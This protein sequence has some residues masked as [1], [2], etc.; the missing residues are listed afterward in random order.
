VALGPRFEKPLIRSFVRRRLTTSLVRSLGTASFLCLCFCLEGWAA[1]AADYTLGPDDQL[2]ISVFDLRAGTGQPYQWTAFNNPFRVDGSGR[3]ALPLIGD[4]PVS[5]MATSELA[6]IIADKLQEKVGLAAKPSASVQIVKYRSFYLLGS[7]D[8]PGAYEYRPGLT[9]LQAVSIGGGLSRPAT[10]ALLGFEREAVSDEGDLRLLRID[11]LALLIR[12]ARLDAEIS[13]ATSISLPHDVQA[14][15][16]DKDV[17]R[18][19]N[20]EQ[21]LFDARSYSLKSQTDTLQETKVLLQHQLD[22]LKAKDA[23]LERQLGIIKQELNQVSGLVS[24]GLAVLP[25]QLEI[26]QNEA[27]FESGRLD[28]EMAALRAQQDL[29]T[30]DRNILELNNTGRNQ[31]LQEA[32]EVRNHLA[33]A[34]EKIKTAQSM[35]VQAEVRAP[36]TIR[37]AAG[38]LLNPNYTISRNSNGSSI[39]LTAQETDLVEPGDVVRVEPT[40]MP[41]ASLPAG[42]T[43]ENASAAASVN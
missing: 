18:L 7:V 28:V 10:D 36:M 9:V 25:R 29:S 23:N 4:V 11:R 8:K 38:A 42:S 33:E 31:A 43:S 2:Q 22:S 17:A 14:Q 34:E 26:E 15:L 19:V 5:G 16:G 32:T 39:T 30:A 13:N 6:G 40:K 1:R 41:T 27:Q 3:L 21:M 12:Q 20:E 37:S 35:L 24:K